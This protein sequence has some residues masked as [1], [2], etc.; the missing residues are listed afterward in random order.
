[1]EAIL[2]AASVLLVRDGEPL[3]VFVVKR[4]EAL[5][6]FGGFYAFPGGRVAPADAET[7]L[8][9]NA[10]ARPVEGDP[11]RCAVIARE[12]FEETGVLI[13]RRADGSWAAASDLDP[14]RRDLLA[15]RVTFG[16]VLLDRGLTLWESD[17]QP[18]GRL[19]TPAFA[20]SRFDTFFFLAYL[21]PGQEPAV[22][23]G[24][25]DQGRWTTAAGLLGE[26]ERGAA[27]VS[28]PTV[29]ILQG[30]R[31]LTRTDSPR[32]LA[33]LFP[34]GGAADPHPIYFAPDVQ[35]IPLRTPV[36][37]PS[38][39]TNAYL[40]GRGPVYLIDPGPA[41]AAE[42]ETLFAVL[43][44]QRAEGRPL[45][46]ILL[47]HHHPDHVGAAAACS[48]RFDVPVWAHPWTAQAL[49]GRMP[50]SRTLREG[51][52]LPLGSAA[53]G[54]AD[55][56]LE[57]LHTPGHAP[58]HVV[59]FD[60]HYGLLFAGDMV[61]TQ[62]SVVIAP[63][64]GDLPVY[65]ASLR[66]LREYPTRLLL[67]GHGSPTAR[68]LQTIDDSL[69]HRAKREEM[70]LAA[71]A[72]HAQTVEELAREI[73]RGVPDELLRFARL[74]VLAGL[75][76]LKGEG[77]AEPLGPEREGPWRLVPGERGARAPCFRGP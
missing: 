24:E 19:V 73:Y 12:L 54:Y 32:Q 57:V 70:L 50:V 59:F 11:I 27:L 23:P 33:A 77:R 7:P 13:A 9:R 21:P 62:S 41:D 37:P 25:L 64:D 48:A 65:L 1:M 44:A 45:G 22:W 28:P 74:Q 3:E 2:P 30:L 31:D 18:L 68:G 49:A 66:R 10:S 36:L 67:P 8:V 5:R 43:E 56:Q 75:L 47:T 76:K 4:A 35:M 61:S 58:G 39:H 55:W 42:Q 38:T 20:A 71:L 51:D 15:D 72:L 40:V 26:R 53:D 60:R 63:P 17:W 6:F 46:T 16:R 34:T 52:R 14:A 29:R 69:A